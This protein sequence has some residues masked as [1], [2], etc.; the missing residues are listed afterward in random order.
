MNCHNVH[1]NGRNWANRNVFEMNKM[2]EYII[3]MVS[4]YLNSFPSANVFQ[5]WFT[6]E[7]DDL[8][9]WTDLKNYS[10]ESLFTSKRLNTR[11]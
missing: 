8:G 9:L 1:E 11:H 3:K 4:P 6:F 10:G 7:N 5:Q 2:V